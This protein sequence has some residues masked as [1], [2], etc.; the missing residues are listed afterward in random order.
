MSVFSRQAQDD[1]WVQG[2]F[3][4]RNE[5]GVGLEDLKIRHKGT[6]R[7]AGY[8]NPN[9]MIVFSPAKL[10]SDHQNPVE[11]SLHPCDRYVDGCSGIGRCYRG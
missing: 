5:S 6:Q 3:T 2:H 7:Q 4:L 1:D 10:R 11:S 8:L 9:G